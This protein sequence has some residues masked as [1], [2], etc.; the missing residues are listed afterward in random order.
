MIKQ[1]DLQAVTQ[2]H[3]DEY[4]QAA[5]RVI[6]SGWYLQG[7]ETRRFETDYAKYTGTDHCIAVANG[8]DALRLI[9]RAYKE[10]G[11]FHDGDEIIVSAHTYIATIIAITDNGL[12]PVLIEPTF[13]HL[14]INI[15]QVESHITP[16][17]KG[18]MIVHLY[19]RMAYT[20]QLGDI[21]RR[22]SLIL[23]EDCAQAQGCT[24]HGIKAGALGQA[25]AH[26]FYP[27]KNIGAMG[28]A[29]AVTT[30][31]A[32]LADTIRTLANYGSRKKYEFEYTGINSRMSEFDAA[33]LDIK[34]RYL[35]EDNAR[36]QHLAD[37]YY[38]NIS[39]PYITLPSRLPHEN[40]VYH[41]FPVFCTHRD[42]LQQH[43]HACGVQ[44]LIHYPIPPH[45][46]KCY[47]SA[48]W[49]K[50]QLS[51]PIT[52]MIHNLELSLPMNQA[53]TEREAQ[54][55]VD[56]IN[57]FRIDDTPADTQQK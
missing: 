43:L 38:D 18:I 27:G 36:R 57:S 37:F 47:E 2:M 4:K 5:S 55:I 20:D 49:N 9:I 46:Q 50:P 24:F 30:S 53:I 22:H 28:D 3:V 15:D 14:E 16:R 44:T 6:S 29:G 26:S 41:Q 34:L 7:E 10:L 42:M 56:A 19:G 54:T 1:L 25:G 35:D 21:C 40:N 12:V 51:L 52:E 33:I 17:T 31:D 32:K 45:K 13:N 23:M 8:L 48:P 11:I 39:N